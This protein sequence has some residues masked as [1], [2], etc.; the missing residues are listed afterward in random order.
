LILAN[1]V[2]A[3]AEIALVALRTT[4]LRELSEAG[5]GA[6]RAALALRNDPETF[7]ATVQV[8]ITV[9]SATAAAF[10]GASIAQRFA[11][12]VAD[13]PML[14]P[15]AHQIALALV[16]ALV[17]YLSI[18][19]GELVPKSVALHAAEQ[20]AL[21]VSRPLLALAWLARP[22]IWLLTQS[23][24]LLLKPF[25]DRTTFTEARY[26]PD[27]IQQLVED[28]MKS[29]SLHPGAAEIASRAL[30]FHELAV[31]EVMV[32]RQDVVMV[33]Q[34]AS[35]ETIHSM[36]AERPHTRLPVYGSSRDDIVGYVHIKDLAARSWQHDTLRLADVLRAPFFVPE[37]K[38]AVD[39]LRDMQQRRVPL[40]VVVDEQGGVAGIITIEDLVEELVGEIFSEHARDAVNITREASGSVVVPGTMAIRELNRT[41]GFDLPDD[42]DWNTV[43]GLCIGMAGHILTTGEKLTLPN[44][45]LVEV[46][47]ASARRIR[48]LRIHA[49]HPNNDEAPER[50]SE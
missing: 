12:L 34:D 33:Q 7:L 20:Y 8:G 49:P 35:E 2:F 45:V 43:A 30:D 29:G 17:A 5:N 24:N 39:L 18:V 9:V 21:I 31:A 50:T 15:Y 19:I 1:G 11:P 26:S 36:I 48:S 23:S 40:A 46:V 27:E 4:R 25:G 37:S 28:A 41:L 22:L 16:V 14:A 42:G 47:D 13:V 3:G 6:A 10:G 38:S 32:P 44:G